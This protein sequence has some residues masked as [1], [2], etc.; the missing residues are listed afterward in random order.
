LIANVIDG[1]IALAQGD[2]TLAHGI[3]TR[4]RLGAVGNVAEEISV[5]VVA[6]APAENAKGTGLVSETAGCFRR[7]HSL[8]E[9][10]AKGLVLALAWMPGLLEEALI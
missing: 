6:K 9:V 10:G 5:H 8:D 3:F 4:L 2:D 1:E 7:R